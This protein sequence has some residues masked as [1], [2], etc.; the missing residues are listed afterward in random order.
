MTL[1]SFSLSHSLF[2]I[3]IHP[4]R[5]SIL[6]WIL[7]A[8]ALG[9]FV[10]LVTVQL[11]VNTAKPNDD[12]AL[13]TIVGKG[14]NITPVVCEKNGLNAP[15]A[16]TCPKGTAVASLN[17]NTI[18]CSTTFGVGSPTCSVLN[19]WNLT[20]VG[21]PRNEIIGTTIGSVTTGNEITGFTIDAVKS[22]NG[23]D[24][25]LSSSVHLVMTNGGACNYSKIS[26]ILFLLEQSA[27]SSGNS[28]GPGGLNQ[29][30]WATSGIENSATSG[31]CNSPGLA[32]ICTGNDKSACN[33]TVPY[34]S[35][36]VTGADLS[37]VVIPGSATCSNA[38]ILD[39]NVKFTVSQANWTL[40]QTNLVGYRV[41]VL[42]TFDACCDRGSA[43]GIDIDCSATTS[44]ETVRTVQVRSPAFNLTR[45]CGNFCDCINVTDQLMPAQVNGRLG[46]AASSNSTNLPPLSTCSTGRWE[47]QTTDT[48]ISN[49]CD[50]S[51]YPDFSATYTASVTN[52]FSAVTAQCV[53]PVT[54]QSLIFGSPAVATHTFKCATPAPECIYSEW[55]AWTEVQAGSCS[56]NSQCMNNYTRRRELQS[57][58]HASYPGGCPAP[59]VE[60]QLQPCST[61]ATECAINP[62]LPNTTCNLETCTGLKILSIENTEY[63]LCMHGVIVP[64]INTTVA[65][66]VDSCSVNCT[67][68]PPV[69]TESECYVVNQTTCQKEITI[70]TVS[71]PGAC[72]NTT[73]CPTQSQTM[74]V[75]CIC[76]IVLTCPTDSIEIFGSPLYCEARCNHTCI[77]NTTC[78]IACVNTFN[79]CLNTCAIQ[80]IG[81]GISFETC[82]PPCQRNCIPPLTCQYSC[83]DYGVC[84]TN[85]GCCSCVTK[86]PP[87][88]TCPFPYQ[89]PA[90]NCSCIQN[91]CN[92][93]ITGCRYNGQCNSNTQICENT[94]SN[95]TMCDDNDGCTTDICHL[96]GICENIFSCIIIIPPPNIIY[97]KYSYQDA[98]PLGVN[99]GGTSTFCSCN[100][101]RCSN[102][103]GTNCIS[104]A[105]CAGVV[106]PGV[107]GELCLLTPVNCADNDPVTLNFC[108][109]APSTNTSSCQFT[110]EIFNLGTLNTTVTYATC[111]NVP[112]H[113]TTYNTTTQQCTV[114]LRDPNWCASNLPCVNSSSNCIMLY[115]E[116]EGKCS[117]PNNVI[118]AG[119]T[120]PSQQCS[121]NNDCLSPKFCKSN[122]L[123]SV[124]C[125]T[126]SYC[127]G[128]S[129]FACVDNPLSCER[130][131]CEGGACNTSPDDSKCPDPGVG[132]TATCDKV[133]CPFGSHCC[134]KPIA[135]ALGLNFIC[136]C[137]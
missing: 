93:Q 43:C 136:D 77:S 121:S 3:T 39:L 101:S 61:A 40:M 106:T 72:V 34:M 80:C 57:S 98:R 78:G 137:Y 105:T 8:V 133:A 134:K 47:I 104:S 50:C 114:G 45:T 2:T 7:G 55:S 15:P 52:T 69:E 68:L 91:L 29:K 23:L 103:G 107:E 85:L 119:C 25:L 63:K 117:V 86:S 97:C 100:Q 31:K 66:T 126:N 135:G 116:V 74:I 115:G 73:M 92:S 111:I 17:L 33:I 118:V 99:V 112:C 109:V 64:C 113:T 9:L 36:L 35:N 46:C 62:P 128:G 123:C 26:S 124:D 42:V 6:G 56:A 65:S 84:A 11:A 96:N 110:S 27:S 67:Y 49:D 41:N 120:D 51:G 53:N 60:Y 89:D 20:K 19:T 125:Q 28:F 16:S 4:M 54:G 22:S 10:T 79:T 95:L 58:C 30:L 44:L 24:V 130:T 75:P 94:Q 48:C 71:A 38:V 132:N 70:N 102:L 83:N 131:V 37:Q 76:P 14:K 13:F 18:N 122:G 90:N 5:P 59:L 82:F 21:L 108:V 127:G 87:V 1:V 81:I 32:Q 129:N 88:I 12:A